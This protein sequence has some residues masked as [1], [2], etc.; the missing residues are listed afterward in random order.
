[1]NL[2]LSKVEFLLATCIQFLLLSHDIFFLKNLLQ[3]T[4]DYCQKN[5]VTLAAEKTKLMVFASK[6]HKHTV[7]YQQ[8]V[9]PLIINGTTIKPTDS[10]RDPK[11][12]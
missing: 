2:A 7:K 9:T 10:W 3:L 1:M 12:H 5:H 4:L 8:A 6:E 11:L